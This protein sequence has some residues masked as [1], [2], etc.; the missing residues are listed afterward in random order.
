MAF[1]LSSIFKKGVTAAATWAGSAIGAML[2]VLR[3]QVVK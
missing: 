2:V 3:V 1:S